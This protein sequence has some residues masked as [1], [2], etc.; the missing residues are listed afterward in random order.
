[1]LVK[2]EW[3]DSAQSGGWH[4]ADLVEFPLEELTCFTVG[5]VV[6]RDEKTIVLAQSWGA[7]EE[8]EF[9]GLWCIPVPLVVSETML[10]EKTHD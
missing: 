1:M 6:H 3:I 10:L 8:S 9:G 2:I 5:L 4:D 7:S